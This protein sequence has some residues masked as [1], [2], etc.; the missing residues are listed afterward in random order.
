MKTIEFKIDKKI[1]IKAVD[2]DREL[3][4]AFRKAYTFKSNK[5]YNNNLEFRTV[6]SK[7]VIDNEEVYSFPPN[8]SYFSDKIIKQFEGQIKFIGVDTR[9]APVLEGFVSNVVPRDYQIPILEDMAEVGYNAILSL[10]TSAGK[11]VMS[12]YLT[13]LLQTRML[14]VATRVS[15]IQNLLKDAKQFNIPDSEITEINAQWLLN[16][17]Y[18]P[19]MYCTAQ[20]LSEDILSELYGKIGLLI[21]E[22]LHLGL[23]GEGNSTKIFEI[24]PKYRL[25]LSATYKSSDY[26]EEFTRALLSN[27][28][29]TSEETIDY[30]IKVHS[31]YLE[32]GQDFH[33]SYNK[34]YT[35]HEKKAVMYDEYNINAV[36]ELAYFL[37]KK[38][39]RGLLIYVEDK[40]AQNSIAQSLKILGLRI[41]ILNSDT[42]KADSSHIINNFDKGDYDVIVAGNSISA[43]V[44]LYR[45]SAIINLNITIN[46]NN[47]IQLI[48]REK[49]FNPE[50]CNKDKIYIQF[51]VR[52]LSSKKW[53]NDCRV[54][55]KF[56]YID[57]QKVKIIPNGKYCLMNTYRELINN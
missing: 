48:G 54:L 13:E 25:Y 35:S 15:L 19:I 10:P 26:G 45:L 33:R 56:D 20:A 28:V 36:K 50:I 9:V 12:L 22:E 39:H 7:E 49:R 52:G 57:F 40:L 29:S 46:E 47:L 17:T 41:G 38:E 44:S 11:T 55:E 32:R 53:A 2:C 43:G 18:T 5:S 4:T 21:G 42:K 37:V 31:F 14:F 16:P 23:T 27:N 24:N 3:K 8:L 34:V 30:K 51:C 1:Y 6:Y